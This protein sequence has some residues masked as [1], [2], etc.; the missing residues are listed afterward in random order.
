MSFAHKQDT[1]MLV[2]E[3]KGKPPLTMQVRQALD[4]GLLFT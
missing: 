3:N 2:R 1:D 4:S